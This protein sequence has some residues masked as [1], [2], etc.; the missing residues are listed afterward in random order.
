MDV[1][2]D[3]IK[4]ALSNVLSIFNGNLYNLIFINA[5]TALAFLILPTKDRYILCLKFI[6][7]IFITSN[8]IYGNI[9]EYRIFIEIIPFALYGFD[10]VLFCKNEINYD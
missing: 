7:L 3:T 10:K 4:N 2:F 8:F 5:G 9:Q 6:A 1:N